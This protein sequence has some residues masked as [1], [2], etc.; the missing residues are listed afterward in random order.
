M[1]RG[2]DCIGFGVFH[3]YPEEMDGGWDGDQMGKDINR[4]FASLT[5]PLHV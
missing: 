4:R 3:E 5:L 2:F 1:W